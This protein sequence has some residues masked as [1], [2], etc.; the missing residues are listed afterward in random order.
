M[1]YLRFSYRIMVILEPLAFVGVQQSALSQ[2]RIISYSPFLNILKGVTVAN[3]TLTVG[4]AVVFALV[5]I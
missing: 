4:H 2:N 1:S 3:K 5:T